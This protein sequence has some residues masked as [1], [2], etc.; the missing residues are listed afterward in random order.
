[1]SFF[2]TRI[3]WEPRHPV[4]GY[5]LLEP[6]IPKQYGLTGFHTAPLKTYGYRQKPG[7][8]PRTHQ[9]LWQNGPTKALTRMSPQ[10]EFYQLKRS[11]QKTLLQ[12]LSIDL[13]LAHEFIHSAKRYANGNN[14]ARARQLMADAASALRSIRSL[15]GRIEDPSEW[16]HI[17][18]KANRLESEINRAEIQ[19]NPLPT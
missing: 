2:T 14:P 15:Q 7:L 5:E 4:Q 3:V 17:N 12:F 1:M 13:D 11:N 6:W 9:K 18:D 8:L 19:S 10:D 16:V